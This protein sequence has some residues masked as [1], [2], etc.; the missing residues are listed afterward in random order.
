METYGPYIAGFVFAVF[1]GF[2]YSKITS[3]RIAL[4]G[5]GVGGSVV[6]DGNPRVHR[7]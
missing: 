6:G 2:V 7:K 5:T 1:V 4:P 3:K